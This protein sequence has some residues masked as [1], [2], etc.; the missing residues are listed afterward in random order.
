MS[1]FMTS[2]LFL[3]IGSHVSQPCRTLKL[4][5]VILTRNWKL[6]TKV[7]LWEWIYDLQIPKAK[8]I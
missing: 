2:Y 8:G 1:L 6:F 4:I 5:G 7:V 3:F